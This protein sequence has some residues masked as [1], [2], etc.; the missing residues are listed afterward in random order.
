MITSQSPLRHGDSEEAGAPLIVDPDAPAT[1]SAKALGYFD[2]AFSALWKQRRAGTVKLEGDDQ[3][4][5]G[6]VELP[7]Y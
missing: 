1:D 6:A 4:T 7:A 5:N 2:L 3:Q